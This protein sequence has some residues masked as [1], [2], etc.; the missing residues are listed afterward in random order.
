MDSG[1]WNQLED[2]NKKPYSRITDKD[3]MK[4]F[5]DL[6]SIPIK[7]P[8]RTL[9]LYTGTKGAEAINRAVN[10]E[11]ILELIKT[12]LLELYLEEKI[13]AS[14]YTKIERL[15]HSDDTENRMLGIKILESKSNGKFA[16]TYNIQGNPIGINR[17]DC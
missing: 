16:I 14:E 9:V 3:I 1:V 13:T 17:L 11:S 4:A 8:A 2:K 6:G 5:A 15:F 12:L 10:E 7:D